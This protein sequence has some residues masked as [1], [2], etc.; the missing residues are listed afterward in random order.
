MALATA[1]PSRT[2]VTHGRPGRA[3]KIATAV[4][5]VAVAIAAI[6]FGTSRA[7]PF[8]EG[9]VLQPSAGAGIPA[10]LF[11][12]AGVRGGGVG[13]SSRAG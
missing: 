8:A 13:V 10:D 7:W 1:A 4:V 2:G 3:W 9:Q 6:A 11:S 12:V 5:V